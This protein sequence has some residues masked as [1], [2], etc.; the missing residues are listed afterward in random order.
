[1]KLRCLNGVGLREFEEFLRQVKTDDLAELPLHLLDDPRY[2]TAFPLGDVELE[3]R[4]F[5]NRAEFAEYLDIRFQDSGIHDDVDVDGVWEWLTLLY[6]DDVCPVRPDGT[7]KIGRLIRY[8]LH[9]SLESRKPSRHLLRG[10]YL[11]HRQFSSSNPASIELLMG[12]PL[13]NYPLIWTHLNE[14]PSIVG[15]LG[16]LDAARELF[17]DADTGRAKRGSGS[18]ANDIRKFG[19]CVANLPIEFD[20]STLSS[21][22]ILALLPAEFDTWIDDSVRRSEIQSARQMLA[23]FTVQADIS[24]GDRREELALR[25][26]E[27]LM[28]FSETNRPTTSH[29]RH[30]RRDAFRPAVLNAYDSRCAV[31][32]IGLVHELSQG[33]LR[34]EVEAAHV[35]PVANGGADLI[36]NGIALCR[37]VHWAFDNGM[38]WIDNSFSV[39]VSRKAEGNNRNE[40]LREFD[41]R[42]LRLPRHDDLKP[43]KE[44]LRW[45]AQKVAEVENP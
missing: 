39:N 1:M 10:S 41:G 3:N 7:R 12:Y 28:G 37:T 21:I 43:S 32:G 34:Y 35:K 31:S 33:E 11:L 8:L 9:P 6:F 16:V 14:R 19:K 5:S 45:H 36:A 40:W 42:Q 24:A 18:S 25:L 26:G 38:V 2:S 4:E 44:A 20:L 17:Y 29:V 22:T 13:D 23:P 15:S 30:L 27:A